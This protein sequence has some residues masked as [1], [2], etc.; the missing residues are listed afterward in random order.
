MVCPQ[1][2]QRRGK[3]ACPALRQTICPACCA[4]KRRTEI[5]CPSDC[6]HLANATAHPSVPARRQHDADIRALLGGLGHLTEVQLRLFF[7]INTYFLRPSADGHHRA[8]DTEVADAAGALAAT[9]ETASRGVIFEHP[10]VTP[11][12]QRMATDLM[13]LLRDVG[14]GAGSRFERDVTEVCR[15]IQSA[16]APAAE[17][18]SDH[19]G[20]LE[21][22][23]RV[24]G[25]QA[26]AEPEPQRILLP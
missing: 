9:F 17:G 1:C 15:A 5:R 2:N 4:T 16:A 6:V 24:M 3:R 10:A 7:L 11:V 18:R 19:R 20:Y 14:K 12:G 22:V 25:E 26:P 13:T 21:R 23:A 8:T